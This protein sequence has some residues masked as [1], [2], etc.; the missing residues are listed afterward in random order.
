MT[1]QGGPRD[2]PPEV[3]PDPVRRSGND[4][5][6]VDSGFSMVPF[7]LAA[8]VVFIGG[9][10]LF[11]PTSETTTPAQRP[12]IERTTPPAPVAP[13]PTPTAPKN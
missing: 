3:D 1:Y 13:A 8:L 10:I 7:L 6:R 2:P 11:G 9:Y 4:L 12:A 5:R